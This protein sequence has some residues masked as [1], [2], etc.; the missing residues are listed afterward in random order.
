MRDEP[1]CD[2]CNL[3]SITKGQQA[4]RQLAGAMHDGTGNL[5]PLPGI[6]PDYSAP[7]VRNQ[8][9]GRELTMARWG[10][11]SPLFALKGRNSDPGVTNVRNVS[12]PHWRRW[13][14]IENRCVVPFTSFAEHE[15]LPDG[16]RSPVWF[17]LH[18]TR[19]LA[20][21]AGIWTRWTSVRKVKEG[22]TTNDLFAFLTTEPNK[23]VG[24]IHPK[25]MPVIL[26]TRE[27]IDTWMTAPTNE[28]LK[29]QR[30]L[31]DDALMIVARGEKEDQ[32]GAARRSLSNR[33][34]LSSRLVS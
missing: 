30:P 5:P 29:L 31:A 33:G 10:M 3:Y 15:K 6:F 7:I 21:F 32:G 14:G 23:I 22:E 28:A 1:T 24:S 26:T 34:A 20:F 16:A 13:L 9:Q 27:E 2:L 8:P 11:P 18:E 25:A 4:I 12:S 19:P 17:S